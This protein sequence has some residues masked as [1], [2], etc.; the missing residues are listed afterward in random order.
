MIRQFSKL[1]R[2]APV[3]VVLFALAM[4]AAGVFALRMTKDRPW[5][6]WSADQPIAEWMTPGF[7]G[8][9]Y[10]IPRKKVIE[11]LDAPVPPPNGPM[12]L[13]ELAAY[14]GVPVEVVLNEARALVAKDARHD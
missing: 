2:A 6:D 14:R 5:K 11:A 3:A 9:A 7:I 12:T 4:G 8:H 10:D 13:A 1:W